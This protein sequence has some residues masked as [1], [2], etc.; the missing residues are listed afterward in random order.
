MHSYMSDAAA[1]AALFIEAFY[2]ECESLRRAHP[3]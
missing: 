2:D 1:N 3:E